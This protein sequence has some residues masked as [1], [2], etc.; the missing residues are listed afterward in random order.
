[1]LSATSSAGLP[2]TYRV[3]SGPGSLV[4][5]QLSLTGA[6]E[7]VIQ[8]SQAGNDLYQAASVAQSVTVAKAMQSLSW[9]P[10]SSLTYRTNLIALDAKAGSG[11]PV[12]Y[13]I[14]SGPGAIVA[15]RMS[16]TGIG[17]VVIAAEQSGDANWLAATAMTNRFTVDGSFGLISVDLTVLYQLPTNV[18]TA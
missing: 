11:L 17:S 7:V 18:P 10:D 16:L 5:N 2:V 8:A 6:G 14:V 13:R 1:M 3:E 4:G 9:S 12:A 15:G